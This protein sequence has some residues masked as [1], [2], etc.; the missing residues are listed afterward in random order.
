MHAGIPW[1]AKSYDTICKPLEKPLCGCVARKENKLA[2][3]GE[4]ERNMASIHRL[5]KNS[6]VAT[7]ELTAGSIEL[8]INNMKRNQKSHETS[9]PEEE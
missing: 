7:S 9:I 6:R 3:K 8:N 2:R 4:E 5:S 1:M